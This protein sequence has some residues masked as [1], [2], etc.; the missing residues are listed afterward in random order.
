MIIN[1]PNGL[2][3]D[4]LGRDRLRQDFLKHESADLKNGYR[5]PAASLTVH[6]RCVDLE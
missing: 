5:Y 2:T 1:R 3:D 6:I 4:T